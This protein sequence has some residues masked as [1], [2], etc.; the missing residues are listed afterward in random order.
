MTLSDIL[1]E[2]MPQ[3]GRDL[4]KGPPFGRN[5]Y[6]YIVAKGPPSEERERHDVL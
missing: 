6:L 1:N 5:P 4:A 3:S 2:G